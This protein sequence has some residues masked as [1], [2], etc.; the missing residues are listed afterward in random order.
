[1]VPKKISGIK[2]IFFDLD[3]TL[4][5]FEKNSEAVI[6]LLISNERLQEQF[7]IMPELFIK[8]YRKIN[9]YLWHLYSQKKISKEELRNSRFT[10]TLE[11]LGLNNPELGWKMEQ[12]YIAQSPYQTLL[13]DGTMEV[14][15]Y[16]SPRYTLH[17]LSNG[18][19][20]VQHIKLRES[21]IQG[22]F[23]TVCIS[24]EMGFQK[25][26]TQIFHLAQQKVHA[27]KSSCL[28]IGDEF[29]N[30]I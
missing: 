18:F 1:M 30:D 24:E 28:M 22:H 29:T 17:I 27:E 15:E 21:G 25:P 5:D 20:E 7:G 6:R 14:L 9:H 4:W 23:Q 2:H 3:R 13:L 10:K 26:E 19:K 11:K 16:L 8:K 12:A